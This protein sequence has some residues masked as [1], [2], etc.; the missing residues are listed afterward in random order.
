MPANPDL[1]IVDLKNA[2]RAPGCPICRLRRETEDRFFYYL[3]YENVNDVGT[4]L[5]LR[6]SL[7]LCPEHAWRLQATEEA[8]WGDGLGNGI[9]Y[10]DLIRKVLTILSSYDAEHLQGQAGTSHPYESRQQRLRRWLVQHGTLGRWLAAHLEPPS[11][12]EN[13][14]PCLVPREGCLAC[15][16]GERSAGGYLLFLTQGLADPDFRAAYLASGGLCLR[17]LRG[18][19]ERVA[20][21]E[22]AHFLAASAAARLSALQRDV[23]EYCRKQAWQYREEPKHP[24]EQASWV[25]AV[26][27]FAGEASPREDDAV[28]DA[29]QRAL[30]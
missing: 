25:R 11:P 21:P 13:L 27:F 1:M 29:R 17:H 8:L 12:V 15:V 2:F 30:A 28:Y 18:A 10:E 16:S 23:G 4:R 20:A 22:T 24:Q 26:A 19:L 6:R 7:G 5:H 3:V 14:L 9:I